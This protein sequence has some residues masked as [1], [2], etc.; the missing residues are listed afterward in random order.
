MFFINHILVSP[1]R[2]RPETS[3]GKHATEDDLFLHAHSAMLT[4][5][6]N[7]NFALRRAIELKEKG[8]VK[9]EEK[10]DEKQQEDKLQHKKFDLSK[11]DITSTEVIK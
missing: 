5:I 9:E 10:V 1:N 4:R 8:A 11:I 2:F 3:G 7:S 6:L